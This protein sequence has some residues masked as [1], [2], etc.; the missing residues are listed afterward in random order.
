MTHREYRRDG[1]YFFLSLLFY[2]CVLYGVIFESVLKS[3]FSIISAAGF[4]RKIHKHGRTAIVQPVIMASGR[5]ID[6]KL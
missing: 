5:S 3:I 1:P 4:R 6:L 2:F